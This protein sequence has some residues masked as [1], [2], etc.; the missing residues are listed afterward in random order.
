MMKWTIGN[1]RRS[2][3]SF[4]Y[5]AS[6][7]SRSSFFILKETTQRNSFSWYNFYLRKQRCWR[8]WLSL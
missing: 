5:D 4:C 6:S 1:Q 7:L 8:R 3:S 2:I